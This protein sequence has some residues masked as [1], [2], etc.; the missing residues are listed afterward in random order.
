M[1][2]N[3]VFTVV[4]KIILLLAVIFISGACEQPGDLPPP[5]NPYPAM[6]GIYFTDD[7]GNEKFRPVKIVC[8]IDTKKC[9]PLNVLD[10]TLK[11][12][13]LAFF[14]YVILSGAYLRTDAKGYYLDFA[15]SLKTLFAQRKKY[16]DPLQHRGIKV[17]LGIKSE[18]G[19]S[20]GYL[21]D[22]KMYAF[23]EMVYYALS[24][25]RLD[26][27][28]F[29]DDA[30]AS[31]YP[32]IA[33]FFPGKDGYDDGDEWLAEQWR[34]G[35]KYFNNIFYVLRDVIYKRSPQSLP[36]ETR[37]RIR[38][39]PLLF[40]R[41]TKFGRVLP[42]RFYVLAGY[43]EFTGSNVEITG[44]FNPFFDRFPVYSSL[45]T[46][47]GTRTADILDNINNMDNS[48]SSWM[49]EE[50][51]G[52]LAIDMDGGEKRNIYFPFMEDAD[53]YG[54]THHNGT[55]V[56]IENLY[57]RFR[58]EGLW[59]YIFFN[60]LKSR[61]DTE[62]DPYYRWVL[63]DEG[64]RET[65]WEWEDDWNPRYVPP[66]AVF[67]RLTEAFFNEEVICSGGNHE[68]VRSEE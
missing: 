25:H 49:P 15:D 28:E 54:I 56:S 45:S 27:V 51:Y 1:A 7:A 46:L 2:V 26:G 11:D 24:S 34:Q 63:F 62:D 21:D 8:Y 40:V 3:P 39:T 32:D 35:G 50:Q 18:G 61:S 31:A 47:E 22:D 36:V 53:Q 41:E 55:N 38:N 9:N 5:I 52:P 33:D 65:G 16:I 19:A 17:L 60:N 30:D 42:N 29:F 58:N 6:K 37:R 44:S 13:G 66:E 20:F 10:Y 64:K 4:R 12:S 59:E 68:K 23:S 57:T 67:S 43:G 48:R 14:D